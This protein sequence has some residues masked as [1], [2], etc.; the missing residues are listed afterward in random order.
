MIPEFCFSPSLAEA[1][2]RRLREALSTGGC[3]S[4][5]HPL[6]RESRCAEALELARAFFALPAEE[7]RNL[8]IERSAHFRGYSEMRNARDWR[9]QIHFGRE[10]AAQGNV[11]AYRQLQGPNLWPEDALW[12]A[13]LLELLADFETAGRDILA[14]VARCLELPGDAL[15][16]ADESPYLLLKLIHY[17]VSDMQSPR[18]GVAP[19]VD[20]SWITLLLQDADGL[21]VRTPAGEWVLAPGVPGAV[22]VNIGEILQFTA[23]GAVSATPH[24]VVNR[25]RDRSRVSMPF[26]LNPALTRRLEPMLPAG[27]GAPA[28]DGEH[29]HRVLGLTD[30]A[31]FVFGDGEWNRKGRGV[32]CTECVSAASTGG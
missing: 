14:G 25:S 23:R 16:G 9:E 30:D 2:L 7:K 8:A 15:M 29:V 13:R 10:E 31:P 5:R 24:R 20:Y 1:D 6:F 11:P 26:F 22:G 18:S 12:R 4:A 21:E 28:D 3:F 32:W 27:A 19:H 17:P